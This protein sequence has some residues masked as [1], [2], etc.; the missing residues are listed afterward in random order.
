[1]TLKELGEYVIC[2]D[3]SPSRLVAGMVSKGLLSRSISVRDKRAIDLSL[4]TAGQKFASDIKRIESN[5]YEQFASLDAS[6]VESLSQLL[7]LLI[8][9]TDASRK[10]EKRF[11][12]QPL[13]F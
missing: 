9:D 6:Q 3:A 12:S 8:S 7:R 11:P 2:E 5:F 1:L 10:V 4:T 13:V